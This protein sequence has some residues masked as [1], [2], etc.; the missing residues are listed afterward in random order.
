MLHYAAAFTVLI[1][2][3]VPENRTPNA[4]DGT[5]AYVL[6]GYAQLCAVVSTNYLY[7]ILVTARAFKQAF[8][9]EIDMKPNTRSDTTQ[10]RS[11][12]NFICLLPSLA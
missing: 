6:C 8:S 9:S 7:K 10:L 12:L 3:T 5:C 4:G 1:R 11:V 2:N